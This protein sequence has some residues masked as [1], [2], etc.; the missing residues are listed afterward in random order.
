[1]HH[2]ITIFYSAGYSIRM[3]QAL[4]WISAL[5]HLCQPFG[6]CNRTWPFDLLRST[7]ADSDS[8]QW[9]SQISCIFKVPER[10][11]DVTA[12]AADKEPF[13]GFSVCYFFLLEQFGSGQGDALMNSHERSFH[14]FLIN[15]KIRSYSKKPDIRIAG[16]ETWNP[17]GWCIDEKSKV[18]GWLSFATPNWSMHCDSCRTREIAWFCRPWR[19]CQTKKKNFKQNSS[20]LKFGSFPCTTTQDTFQAAALALE[21]ITPY[22]ATNPQ[23]WQAWDSQSEQR[24]RSRQAPPIFFTELCVFRA[25]EML[26]A[27]DGDEHLS[28]W[29]QQELVSSQSKGQNLQFPSQFAS[30]WTAWWH[31]RASQLS[32]WPLPSE[33]SRVN[34]S[35]ASNLRRPRRRQKIHQAVA[36]QTA[37]V[38]TVSF[39]SCHW[40]VN[41]G[42]NGDDKSCPFQ[43]IGPGGRLSAANWHVIRLS[44][45]QKYSSFSQTVSDGLF[46]IRRLLVFAKSSAWIWTKKWKHTYQG[47]TKKLHEKCENMPESTIWAAWGLRWTCKT[48]SRICRYLRSKVG[49]ALKVVPSQSWRNSCRLMVPLRSW[50]LRKQNCQAHVLNELRKF[51]W[52]WPVMASSESSIASSSWATSIQWI[53]WCGRFRCSENVKHKAKCWIPQPMWWPE[54]DSFWVLSTLPCTFSSR[55]RPAKAMWVARCQT[56]IFLILMKMM[57]FAAS[58]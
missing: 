23:I 36:N 35:F 41:K 2:C 43:G 53:K 1:M 52:S 6:N 28:K 54:V 46:L 49:L 39:I 10:V 37:T 33:S 9:D 30:S 26:R 56:C 44:G 25:D 8:R 58:T 14:L 51:E 31:S 29:P 57:F 18:F 5:S 3:N 21:L 42:K 45:S 17:W 48:G 4:V 50:R 19:T 38:A 40:K 24:K 15:A 32:S 16:S 20:K 22:Q 11:T 27:T 47:T 13:F 55:G 34:R 12:A 7:A